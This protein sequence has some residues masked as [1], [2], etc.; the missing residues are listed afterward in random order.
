MKA[1][2]VAKFGLPEVLVCS[3]NHTIP[4]PAPHEILVKVYAAG[5]NPVETYIRAG[6]YGRLPTLP[7]TPG[8]DAA[9]V[10]VKLGSDSL[11]S[12][13]KVNDRIFTSNTTSGSYAEYATA[14]AGSCFPL[15]DKMSFAQGATLGTPYFTAFRAL[16][17]N[18]QAKS[19]DTVLVHGASGTVGLACCQMGAASGLH[20]IGTA[21]TDQGLECVK[22]NGASAVFNHRNAGYTNEIMKHTGGKGVNIIVEMLANVNLVTDCQLAAHKGKILVVGSRGALN[23]E[24]RLT[25]AKELSIIGVALGLSSAEDREEQAKGVLKFIEDGVVKPVVAK[26]YPLENACAAHTDVI[27]SSGAVGKLVLNVANE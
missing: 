4:I 14:P 25:M 1:I 3:P 24:P 2:Q 11:A 23:F 6:T 9:G 12:K 7:Y 18:G 8:N 27:E 13:F 15:S 22:A 16:F 10:I 26:S 21:G 20:V 17:Q 19:G 5:V